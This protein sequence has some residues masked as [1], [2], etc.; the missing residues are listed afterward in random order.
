MLNLANDA[1]K[2]LLNLIHKNQAP[3]IASSL[4]M[5]DFVTVIVQR[6]LQRAATLEYR[7]DLVL[8]KGHAAAGF[9][10]VLR[11]FNQISVEDFES[12]YV[13]GS[14][15]YGHISHKASNWNLLTTG[16][17]GHGLPFSTGLALANKKSGRILQE[18]LVIMS[19]GECDEGSVWESALIASHHNLINLKVIIDRN[20]LQS[21]TGT[22]STLALEPLADK[23]RAF[24]WDVISVDGH[25]HFEI[26]KALETASSKPLCVIANTVKGKGISFMENSVLWHYKAPN[27]E[28]FKEAAK[29]LDFR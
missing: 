15:F 18:S 11:A 22:E 12:F 23:W 4:S 8:S 13:D 5:I 14:N 3:H 21:L 9:Y 16:S 1:R 24:G 7:D 25:S 19:D 20:Q 28:E 26:E 10:S 17:L 6:S 27:L 29:E 2:N